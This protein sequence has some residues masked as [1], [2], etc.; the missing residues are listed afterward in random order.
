MDGT[1]LSNWGVRG[2]GGALNMLEMFAREGVPFTQQA[3]TDLMVLANR[4]TR[5][6]MR[7]AAE[8]ITSVPTAT[9]FD[10]PH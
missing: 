9:S 2:L 4:A 1:K 8:P 6:A 7:V 3:A 10:R 5:L